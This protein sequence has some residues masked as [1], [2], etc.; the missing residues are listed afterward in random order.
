MV[1]GRANYPKERFASACQVLVS[2]PEQALEQ[3]YIDEHTVFLL[4]TH[5]YNYDMAMLGQLLQRNVVYIGIL[6]PK[7][8]RERLLN[9]LK[10]RDLFLQSN[11]FLPFI[12]LLAWIL[13][14]KHR[15][16]SPYQFLQK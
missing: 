1:D 9:E 4:M 10:G 2:K 13:V 7:K 14:Q 15:K 11:N 6:G 5:N 16:R 12:V 8:K 3:I